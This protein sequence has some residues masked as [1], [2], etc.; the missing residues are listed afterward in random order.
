[1]G[2]T[3][4][5]FHVITVLTSASV[6][7]SNATIPS[8]IL[9]NDG[10]INGVE[11][12]WRVLRISDTPPTI[13]EPTV[14]YREIRQ[15]LVNHSTTKGMTFREADILRSSV[16]H[17]ALYHIDNILLNE[18]R[19]LR[20]RAISRFQA[21][22][23]EAL[24]FVREL[25]MVSHLET[26]VVP[27]L[28]VLEADLIHFLNLFSKR[29]DIDIHDKVKGLYDKAY[30]ATIQDPDL[31]DVHPIRLITVQALANYMYH[32]R[33][34]V[35]EAIR[36]TRGALASIRKALKRHPSKVQQAISNYIA[37]L[38]HDLRIWEANNGH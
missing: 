12:P 16:L 25:A 3:C 15:I 28:L 29:L 13:Q 36:L 21:F 18:E 24:S 8:S 20:H 38:N 9:P 6:L 37:P 22:G 17:H 10:P 33:L 2:P 7:M 1:M 31:T 34:G 11:S 27:Y 5:W 35:A 23:L 14:A 19:H 4:V 30:M 32:R 26:G